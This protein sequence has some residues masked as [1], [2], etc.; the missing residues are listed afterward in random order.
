M[1]DVALANIKNTGIMLCQNC[2]KGGCYAWTVVARKI[3]KD[4]F[5]IVSHYG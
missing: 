2:S 3:Y 5:Y 1:V 4:Y